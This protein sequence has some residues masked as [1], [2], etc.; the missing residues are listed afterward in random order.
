MSLCT[1]ITAGRAWGLRILSRSISQCG[2]SV[3][4]THV[5]C[6]LVALCFDTTRVQHFAWLQVL[7]QTTMVYLFSFKMSWVPR[8]IPDFNVKAGEPTVSCFDFCNPQD[9]DA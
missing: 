3:S 2:R 4:S 5:L 8:W 1:A 6:M 7:Y 9:A